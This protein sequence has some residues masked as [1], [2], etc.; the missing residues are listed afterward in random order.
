MTFPECFRLQPI[1]IFPCEF[2]TNKNYVYIR[3]IES[4]AL[5]VSITD[6]YNVGDLVKNGGDDTLTAQAMVDNGNLLPNTEARALY[7]KIFAC[8]A[9]YCMLCFLFQNLVTLSD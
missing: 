5:P 4:C 9:D 8:S 1:A 2:V 6:V 7:V 3:F